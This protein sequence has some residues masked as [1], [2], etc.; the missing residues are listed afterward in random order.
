MFDGDLQKLLL[1]V[2]LCYVGS[3]LKSSPLNIDV[4]FEEL[5]ALGGLLWPISRQ[6]KALL[7]LHQSL[8]EG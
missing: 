8:C 2:R 5:L 1:N 4:L 3:S 7:S 6:W